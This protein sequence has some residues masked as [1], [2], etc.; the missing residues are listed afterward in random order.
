M[1]TSAEPTRRRQHA[2]LG[3]PVPA[4]YGGLQRLCEIQTVLAGPGS[5]EQGCSAVAS[6]MARG[7]RIR[8]VMLVDATQDRD[9]TLSWAAPG[10]GADEVEQA[11]EHARTLLAYLAPAAP[12]S[13]SVV[14]STTLLRGGV[15]EADV[16]AR[17]FITLPLVLAE[18][19]AFGVFQ[20]EGVAAFDERDLLFISA[21]ANHV[22][23]ALDRHHAVLH[24]QATRSQLDHAN[25]RLRDLQ[26]LSKVALGGATL[27]ESLTAVLTVI[28]GMFAA[29]VAAVLLTST[30]GKTLERRA[31]I[32]LADVGDASV[33]VG[34]GAA[35][36][37]AAAR[38]AMFFD[39]L[40][41]VEGEGEGEDSAL[42]ASR[43]R[44]LIGAPMLARDRVIGVVYVASRDRR[45]FTYD[46]LQMLERAADRLGTILDNAA[47]HERALGAIESRDAMMGV[48]SH[49]LRSPVNSILLGA[50]LIERLLSEADPR[51]TR[52]VSSIKRSAHR[53]VRMITDLQDV[54]S[55]EAGRLSIETRT[56]DARSLIAEAVEGAQSA[57]AAHSL[58]LERRAIERELAVTCDRGR[59]MQLV[60]NLLTNA[61][62]FTPD[63]G[64]I[65]IAV[66]QIGEGYARFSVEDTGC[67]IPADD[68]PHVF[69]RYWQAR[70]TARLGT[71]LGLAI[72]KGI[73]Q[74]HGG[75]LCVESRVGQGT[76]F[77]F[78]L[79]LAHCEL[80]KDR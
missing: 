6:I 59:V 31:S 72:A 19:G 30:D 46:E 68:L 78:T 35:G 73:A 17:C 74:A 18:R 58:R 39:A 52:G 25:H 40:E 66:T 76:T 47:L 42:R 60:A 23:L 24:L 80:E 77:S 64:V 21:V 50:E 7:L 56:E 14:S 70:N 79:P 65:T 49:D 53:M 2:A 43:V 51:V 16:G 15:V 22:A 54:G 63:G 11:R 9:R 36:R 13:A 5:I 57:A 33:P 20:V 61:I 1:I 26:A 62:K 38:S 37:I 34:S 4:D 75:T 29:N 45:G 69:D 41:E 67:G 10:I 27:D 71:G 48:V 44:S 28:C 32:G 12:E 55:I 3:L 8:T